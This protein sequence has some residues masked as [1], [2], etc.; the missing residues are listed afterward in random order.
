MVEWVSTLELNKI[1][2]IFTLILASD[3]RQYSM[4][5]G[6]NY[7]IISMLHVTVNS[8]FSNNFF[9]L[10]IQN[11]KMKDDPNIKFIYKIIE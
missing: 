6:L 8:C 11:H 9:F 2:F 7:L 1:F 5:R 3:G 4:N 10:L